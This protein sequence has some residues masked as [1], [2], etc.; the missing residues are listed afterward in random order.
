MKRLRLRPP[1]PVSNSPGH[2]TRKKV[3]AWDCNIYR[4]APH[5]VDGANP[6]RHG[7]NIG[8]P[9][10]GFSDG[11]VQE[12]TVGNNDEISSLNTGA[13]G[14]ETMLEFLQG[15]ADTLIDDENQ[16]QARLERQQRIVSMDRHRRRTEGHEQLRRRTLHALST[17]Q[18]AARSR[19][20]GESPVDNTFA[21]RSR[22]DRPLPAP[23]SRIPSQVS[24]NYEY[25]PPQW[26]PDQDVAECPICHTPFSFLRRKHHCRKCGR[27][28]C[29]AC[30]PH[31]ITIPRQ[32]IVR[33]PE[34]QAAAQ[35]IVDLTGE[36]HSSISPD[37]PIQS[38]GTDQERMARV[39]SALGGGEVVR[40]CNPCVPDPNPNPMPQ[41]FG[42]SV[43]D[44]QHGVLPTAPGSQLPPIPPFPVNT[45]PP[46]PSAP[47]SSAPPPPYGTQYPAYGRPYLGPQTQSNLALPPVRAP[48]GAFIP[49][50]GLGDRRSS[51][52]FIRGEPNNSSSAFNPLG[53]DADT[54]SV[55]ASWGLNSCTKKQ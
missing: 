46:I 34:Q 49:P 27:V 14:R 33:P 21:R 48:R 24:S 26:Q 5:R 15:T 32:F 35:A 52:T 39:N 44:S 1:S 45:T 23:P 6:G 18:S 8:P 11:E 54:V 30:S 25:R 3:A 4:M 43:N 41:G 12:A 20:S 29:N 19:E 53:L 37:R 16:R 28:V 38:P 50:T 42:P 40:L 9:R 47:D 10:R 13:P 51:H 17:T 22:L 7:Q 36:D 31:R 55:T 2:Y